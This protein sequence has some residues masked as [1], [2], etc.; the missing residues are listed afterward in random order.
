[1][2]QLTRNLLDRNTEY[3]KRNRLAPDAVAVTVEQMHEIQMQWE[4]Y[5]DRI[6]GMQMLPVNEVSEPRV[7]LGNLR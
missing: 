4:C 3:R 6:F 7:F 1:M 2:N 5:G